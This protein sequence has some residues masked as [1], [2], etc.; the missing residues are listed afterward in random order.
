MQ[1]NICVV[2]KLQTSNLSN[3][4]TGTD[5]FKDNLKLNDVFTKNSNNFKSINTT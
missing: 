4:F 3:A 5:P 2:L 1:L